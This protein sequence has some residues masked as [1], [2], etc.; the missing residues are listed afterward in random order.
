MAGSQFDKD[1]GYLMP[2]LEKIAAA[3]GQ[4]TDAA[5]REELTRLM[6]EESVRWPRIR[7]LLSGAAGKS[8]PTAEATAAAPHSPVT[9]EDQ[10]PQSSPQ[11][12]VGSLRKQ[13]R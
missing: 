6:A 2:F 9:E 10:P 7:E 3:A 1:F 4:L 11:F 13:P 12:T 8:A 5:A